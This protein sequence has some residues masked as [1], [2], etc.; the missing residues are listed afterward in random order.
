MRF[1]FKKDAVPIPNAKKKQN[2]QNIY[3]SHKDF[4][5]S[6]PKTVFSV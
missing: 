3:K 6:M 2:T 5:N 1:V 4:E